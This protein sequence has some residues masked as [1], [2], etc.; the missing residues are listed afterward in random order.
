MK[1]VAVALSLTVALSGCF[2]WRPG[3]DPYGRTLE[4]QVQH[5]AKGVEAYRAKAGVLPPSLE[6]LVPAYISSLPTGC[7]IDTPAR[8]T[9]CGLIYLRET[10]RVLVTYSPTWPQS[11]E[12]SC[13]V[14]VDAP[15]WRCTGYL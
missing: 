9:R 7:S 4:S 6:A 14:D 13:S 10:G 2:A 15:R 1:R 3:E 8:S 12:I 11:G 5:V